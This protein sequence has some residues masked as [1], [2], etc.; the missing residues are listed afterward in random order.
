MQ[1]KCNA[2]KTR[3]KFLWRQYPTTLKADEVWNDLLCLWGEAK[4]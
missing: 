4:R 1:M 3:D 2:N